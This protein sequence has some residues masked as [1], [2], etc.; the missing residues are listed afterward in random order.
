M[1]ILYDN[2]SS[3]ESMGERLTKASLILLRLADERSRA[4]AG[5]FF[6]ELLAQ[7]MRPRF[8]GNE[9]E[10]TH[11][12]LG[13]RLRWPRAEWENY[14]A[15]EVE[16]RVTATFGAFT[17]G[18]LSPID[19]WV[20]R[21]GTVG[22]ILSLMMRPQ[23]PILSLGLRSI[24]ALWHTVNNPKSI[25]ALKTY[26]GSILAGTL[27]AMLF[28]GA[29]AAPVFG[30]FLGFLEAIQNLLTEESEEEYESMA[31]TN[32]SIWSFV[33]NTLR[34]P[35]DVA[36]LITKAVHTGLAGA[37][38]NINLTRVNAVTGLGDIFAI[39]FFGDLANAIKRNQLERI[40]RYVYIYRVLDDLN[41]WGDLPEYYAKQPVAQRLAQAFAGDPMRVYMLKPSLRYSFMPEQRVWGAHKLLREVLTNVEPTQEVITVLAERVIPTVAMR[42]PYYEKRLRQFREVYEAGLDRLLESNPGVWQTIAEVVG[43]AQ[44]PTRESYR[45]VLKQQLTP[46]WKDIAEILATLD[47]L[48][49]P[50]VRETL[51][52]HRRSGE[53]GGGTPISN[54]LLKLAIA[55]AGD[56]A[57]LAR[58]VQRL[59]AYGRLGSQQAGYS[60]LVRHLSDSRRAASI[61]LA[62]ES[63][64]YARSLGARYGHDPRLIRAIRSVLRTALAD[65]DLSLEDVLE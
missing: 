33:R 13:V 14:A 36:D 42:I 57:E 63:M 8:V 32:Q 56:Q 1:R 38:F 7:A 18:D 41:V 45:E 28:G 20:M 43:T 62:I 64:E 19:Q 23:L 4:A 6:S 44:F 3:R 37:V 34:V 30:Q 26:G 46:R 27:I 11:P 61:I 53:A 17:R 48:D 58:D 2:L 49:D 59:R 25:K 16:K 47:A 60:L 40:A 35:A 54:L 22:D 65:L 24:A 51:N 10:F 52:A 9:V 50:K 55:L 12:T 15:Q 39:K 31:R 29:R 5:A 21:S